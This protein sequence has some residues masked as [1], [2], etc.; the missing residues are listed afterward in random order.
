MYQWILIVAA[1]AV[2]PS[3]AEDQEPAGKASRH[4]RKVQQEIADY[5]AN[6]RNSLSSVVQDINSGDISLNKHDGDRLRE[7]LGYCLDTVQNLED[8]GIR[9][10]YQAPPIEKHEEPPRPGTREYREA[11]PRIPNN[12]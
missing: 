5:Y 8:R 7:A 2:A 6:T 1:L 4:E 12:G 11:N 9:G 10:H 3:F